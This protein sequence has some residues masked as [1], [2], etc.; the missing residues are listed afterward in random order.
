MFFILN[1]SSF[2]LINTFQA[3]LIN[4]CLTKTN[5]TCVW[6]G[7]PVS[8]L[9]RETNSLVAVWSF[10]SALSVFSWSWDLFGNTAP[11][12]YRRRHICHIILRWI[13]LWW[14]QISVFV[15]IKWWNFWLSKFT[16]EGPTK[17]SERTG[18]VRRYLANVIIKGCGIYIRWESGADPLG[19]WT[20]IGTVSFLGKLVHLIHHF[21]WFGVNRQWLLYNWNCW[22]VMFFTN[23]W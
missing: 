19:D 2:L 15:F 13:H 10:S 4:T 23:S 6:L 14:L 18:V 11:M 12:I 7:H 9:S 21:C 20:C 22:I 8:G 1:Y 16:M 3:T 5:G 17:T